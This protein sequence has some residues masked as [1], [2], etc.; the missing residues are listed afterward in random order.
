MPRR[1]NERNDT[2]R[3]EMPP[4]QPKR[5]RP[6]VASEYRELGRPESEELARRLTQR[7]RRCAGLPEREERPLRPWGL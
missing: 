5:P 6:H 2:D 7:A 1:R 4:H 3:Y